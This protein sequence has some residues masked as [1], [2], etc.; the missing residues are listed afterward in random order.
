MHEIIKSVNAEKT[1]TNT[2]TIQKSVT[3]WPLPENFE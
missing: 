2:R 3:Y 1:N